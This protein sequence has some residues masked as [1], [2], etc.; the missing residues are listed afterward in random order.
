[1]HAKDMKKLS[2][3]CQIEAGR[4]S[5]PETD[6]ARLQG[7]F[8][9]G[10]IPIDIIAEGLDEK[11]LNLVKTLRSL[12]AVHKIALTTNSTM[13][14]DKVFHNLLDVTMKALNSEIGYI[15]LYDGERKTFQVHTLLDHS[16]NPVKIPEIPLSPKSV[17]TWV[18]NSRK[19]T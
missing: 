10:K 1:M 9:G 17:S 3:S 6:A 15:L 16:G 11:N 8:D 2:W 19:S 12:S 5:G 18:Y 4:T 7:T 14:L 13:E